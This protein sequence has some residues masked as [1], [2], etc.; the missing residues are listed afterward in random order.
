MNHAGINVYRGDYI[1]SVHRLHIA[2][3]NNKGELI[4]YLGDP[5]RIFFARSSMK[6]LQA[7]TLIETGAGQAFSFDKADISL[8][9]ASHNG[10]KIHR[11]RVLA[12]LDRLGLTK[13]DLQ[14]GTH[15]PRD[16]ESY[17]DL[18]KS[19]QELTPEFCNCSGK[20][21]GM[22][23]TAIHLGEEIENYYLLNHPVQQRIL[24]IISELLDFS[25]EKINIGIDGCGV[26]VH[27][28]P[29]NIAAKGF[30]YL[31]DPYAVTN[32]SYSKALKIIRDSMIAHPE[33][34][35]GKNRFNTD[36]MKAF[37]GRIVSKSGAEGVQC[38]GDVER[39]IG[40]AIKTEDGNGRAA[41][42]AMMEVFKQ[43][44]IG[45]DKIY[46]ELEEYIEKP[47]KNHRNEI[48]GTIRP[49]FELLKV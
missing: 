14:C 11:S 33:M 29:I 12:I 3:V 31:A 44:G 9:C 15:I 25:K 48:I 6:P 39:G 23:A 47:I 49:S 26:P 18:I 45:N 37:K 16:I 5:K 36:V 40:I 34:V 19:G 46:G 20:H 13:D 43:L 22:L 35:A 21:A 30:A 1:E 4:Y 42:V 41:I 8:A 2:V 7:I 28:M 32:Q 24:D 27:M 38:A 10:E 17:K